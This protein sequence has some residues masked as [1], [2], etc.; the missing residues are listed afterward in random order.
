MGRTI[1]SRP[2]TVLRKLL[3]SKCSTV[4]VVADSDGL[5]HRRNTEVSQSDRL[6]LTLGKLS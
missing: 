1:Q 2:T 3:Y 5:P 6:A 4:T